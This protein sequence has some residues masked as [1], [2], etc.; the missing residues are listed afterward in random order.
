MSCQ[1]R[2]KTFAKKTAQTYNLKNE[3]LH[4]HFLLTFSEL[5]FQAT[6]RLA[7]L[8]VLVI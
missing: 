2:R 1:N 8:N 7:A 4:R 5:N 3:L 6:L